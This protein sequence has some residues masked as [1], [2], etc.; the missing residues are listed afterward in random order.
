MNN[1]PTVW[2]AFGDVNPMEHGGGFWKKGF[3][4]E[5]FEIILWIPS[6]NI[7]D[8]GHFHSLLVE[9]SDDWIDQQAVA[10]Y[11]DMKGATADINFALDCIGYYGVE[12][13][14]GSSHE[15]LIKV[16]AGIERFKIITAQDAKTP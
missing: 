16:E 2:T 11:G 4:D 5:S 15:E 9:T 1:A 7:E 14:G 8:T 13:F 10:S 3:T 12:N 6:E